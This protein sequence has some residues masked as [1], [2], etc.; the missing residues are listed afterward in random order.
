MY[1]VPVWHYQWVES[2]SW[3]ALHC[4]LRLI[5][6]PMKNHDERHPHSSQ[7]Y[8]TSM[9]WSWDHSPDLRGLACSMVLIASSCPQLLVL[10]V[11]F[12]EYKNSGWP[13]SYAFYKERRDTPL[14][15]SAIP[16]RLQVLRTDQPLIWP[17]RKSVSVKVLE[18]WCCHLS[19][20]LF[21]SRCV[22]S[23]AK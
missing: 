18:C 7:H 14:I 23:A 12:G 4:I 10:H 21:Y 15:M 22:L 3:I 6:W 19:Q 20:V 2:V 8:W 5:C 1:S 9:L 11:H 16:P 13:H 17:A